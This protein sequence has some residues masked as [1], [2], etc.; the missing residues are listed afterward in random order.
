MS[1]HHVATATTTARAWRTCPQEPASFGVPSLQSCDPPRRSLYSYQDFIVLAEPRAILHT[2]TRAWPS[3]RPPGS[4][5]E[6]TPA[7]ASLARICYRDRRMQPGEQH[8]KTT[9]DQRSHY[10]PG[11][12]APPVPTYHLLQEPLRSLAR[13][14][15]AYRPQG[16]LHLFRAEA[17]GAVSQ[18]HNR[19]LTW[20]GRILPVNLPVRQPNLRH[21]LRLGRNSVMAKAS[22]LL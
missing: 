13:P 5:G 16:L 11:M 18:Q 17:M 10:L 19:L 2:Q 22:H 6:A 7:G 20:E 9:K 15:V 12:E 3:Q 14:A 21:T 8:R 1:A 4:V